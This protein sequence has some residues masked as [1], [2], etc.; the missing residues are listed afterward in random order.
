M[1]RRRTH[2]RPASQSQAS[3]PVKLDERPKI[4][5]YGDSLTSG[6]GLAD[7]SQAYPALMQKALENGGYRFQVLNYGYGGDTTERGLARLYLATGITT[8]R[9]FVVE[10]GANDVT[11]G[12]PV[13]KIKDNL[14]GILSKLRDLEKTV[15]LCGIRAPEGQ[16][17][18][19]AAAVA[20]MY[21]ELS[22]EYG[23]KLMP[24]FMAGVSGHSEHLLADGIH[25]NEAGARLIAEAVFREL[26]PL[27][28][29]NE[30]K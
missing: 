20:R 9:V 5:A 29:Q 17:P 19:Y 8:S 27:L 11:Q 21:A 10:L 16:D 6:F 30:K 3:T 23:V 14:R 12:V 25:P 22:Q 15:L 13:D 24:D 7:R 18:E 28:S 2:N 26:R 4:I 1:C